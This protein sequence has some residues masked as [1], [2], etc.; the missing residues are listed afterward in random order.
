MDKKQ[1]KSI[2]ESQKPTQTN[3]TK[4]PVKPQQ[5]DKNKKRK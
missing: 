1:I 2:N 5:V 3:K 4:P